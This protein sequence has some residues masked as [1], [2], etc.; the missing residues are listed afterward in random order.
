MKS[1]LTIF[2]LLCVHLGLARTIKVGPKESITTVRAGFEA[3][4]A[5]DTVLLKRGVYKEGNLQLTKS[6]I[7]LGEP[8]A[9]LDGED[10]NEI[11]TI[12]GEGI[13]VKGITF[14]NAGYS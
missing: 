13:V 12:S 11:L 1:F 4:Q 5:G 9:V 2:F 10:K 7:L 14:Q 8:G 6:I 3:A